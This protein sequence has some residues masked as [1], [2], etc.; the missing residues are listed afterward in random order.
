MQRAI[1]CLNLGLVEWYHGAVTVDIAAG[2]AIVT[3]NRT[4]LVRLFQNFIGNAIKYQTPGRPPRIEVR[5]Q[6]RDL[7][8]L[9]SV[10]D[11]GIG[12][13]SEFRQD[14]FKIFRR[15]HTSEQYEGTGIG[16]AVCQKIVKNYGGHIW[17]ESEV[18]EGSTFLFTIPARVIT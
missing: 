6:R 16:L 4:E 17:I 7:D 2:P 8:W 11:N 12:I 3:G 18:G 13:P 5:W 10:K 1:D 14:V 9:V 15:L